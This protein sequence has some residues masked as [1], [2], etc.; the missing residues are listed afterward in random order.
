MRERV[1]SRVELLGQFPQMGLAMDG[2]YDGLRQL[3]VGRQ[4]VIY[5]VTSTDVRIAYIRHGARQLGLRAI[6][7]GR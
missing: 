6:R 2:P 5:Q 4:R 1:L 3:L 7:G